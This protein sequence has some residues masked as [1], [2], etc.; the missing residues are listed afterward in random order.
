M[1]RETNPAG[2]T[3]YATYDCFGNQYTCTLPGG[4]IHEKHYDKGNHVTCHVVK[5]EGK[6][7]HTYYKYNHKYQQTKILD[8]L[9]REIVF[10]Y[11]FDGNV[12][13]TTFPKVQNEDGQEIEP[14][15][16][17]EYNCLGKKTS[18]TTPLRCTTTTRYNSRGSPT[19]ITYPD[20]T[21]EA[22][23]YNLDGTLKTAIDQKGYETVYLYNTCQQ[24]IQKTV[25]GMVVQTFTYNSFHVTS[26][27]DN[28]GRFTT[29]TYDKAGRKDSE[30]TE[31][32]TIAYSYDALGFLACTTSQ[33]L[34][35]FTQYNVLGQ[36]KEE[37]EENAEKEILARTRYFYDLAGNCEEIIRYF[38]D[39]VVIE[40]TH[41]DS[42]NRAYEKK[43][44]LGHSTLIFYSDT[45]PFTI[46]EIDPLG[47][48][49]ITTF[50]VLD[51]PISVERKNTFG[52]Q[53]A[54]NEMFYTA[55]G[56][57]ALQKTA[58]I[59]PDGHQETLMTRFKYDSMGRTIKV[60]EAEG[61][62]KQKTTTYGYTLR[63]ERSS[64]IKPDGVVLSYIFDPLGRLEDLSS[65]IDDCHYR[66]CYEK[67][68]TKPS[69]IQD[70]ITGKTT[71]R[72]YDARGRLKKETLATG[73]TFINRYDIQGRRLQLILPD[74]SFIRYVYKTKHLH[75]VSRYDANG[76]HAYTHTYTHYDKSGVPR[77]Q[78]LI[79]N[80]GTLGH[81]IDV[82]GR[83][84]H[85]CST[86]FNQ[87]ID[88]IDPCG[89]IKE[90]RTNN[91]PRSFFYDSLK[92]LIDEEGHAYVC[93]S[94]GRRIEKDKERQDLNLLNHLFSKYEYDRNGNP[95]LK[96]DD[97]TEYIY[98]S[99]DRLT[100]VVKPS[101]SRVIYTYD[102][103]HR[104]LA[105]T[106]YIWQND[107]WVQEE[108]LFFLYDADN[109]IGSITS[110]GNVKELR[111]LGAGHGAEIGAAVA[112]ELDGALYAPVHDLFGNITCLIDVFTGTIASSIEYTAFGEP[113]ASQL[114]PWGFSSK[115]TDAETGFV[116][117]GRRYYVP[118]LGRFLTPDPSG[119]TD[120]LNLYAYLNHSPLTA[121]DLYGLESTFPDPFMLPHLSYNFSNLE[122]N[123]SFE[124]IIQGLTL[125]C[126]L[127]GA[128]FANIAFHF[129]PDLLGGEYLRAFGHF[130]LNEAAPEK[131]PSHTGSVGQINYEKVRFTLVNGILTFA[132]DCKDYA[133][134]VSHFLG[135]AIVNYMYNSS[136][137]AIVDL[138]H[139]IFSKFGYKDGDARTLS[140]KWRVDIDAMGGVNGGGTINH[141]AFSEGGLI[142]KNALELLTPEERQMIV[143][144]TFG[145]ASLFS[146]SLAR[147]VTHFVSVR[148]VVPMTDT[149]N[150]IKAVYCT[151]TSRPTNVV[152]VGTW[153]GI[154][155]IDHGFTN[156]SYF[157]PMKNFGNNVAEYCRS[158]H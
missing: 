74:N 32:E 49:A 125:M 58:L 37:R 155:L 141:V 6:K 10:E 23:I 57:L 17:A 67:T 75:T 14:V 110:E 25:A 55:D 68:T 92:H 127:V 4:V 62:S 122:S 63:G 152:F 151:L 111:V 26:Q 33:D 147:D 107:V 9:N 64:I 21:T 158:M 154:P 137:G 8:Y 29:Y 80:L 91:S 22:F 143:V 123:F 5:A 69:L 145:S 114:S 15:A 46:T 76:V 129:V 85:I 89:N 56:D 96:R 124:P 3:T 132:D 81:G 38:D 66:Y 43:D 24:L 18:E 109:E 90:I 39:T 146:S 60:V 20:G 108:I 71:E 59:S 36:L 131:L 30:T 139:S 42:W 88:V 50:D 86:Y 135:G 97:N 106:F 100:E 47:N 130:L 157:K 120:G 150:Y 40:V 34:H 113:S 121:H 140:A 84:T 1:I 45:S 93:D 116:Y 94:L 72:S 61:A 99:L 82:L 53:T 48:Q 35:L 142:T 16:R 83:L 101:V 52:V 77:S 117:F 128:V 134:L 70:E 44:P 119:F 41:H 103:L 118:E 7:H 144:Y 79:G 112:V 133:S 95:I 153:K 149:F 148:D 156:D 73:L 12:I 27:T 2:Q 28:E 54:F 87:Q 65:S 31:G 105:K 126:N 136:E 102:P 78:E 98:D 11:D 138:C 115:R 104:R 19:K 51:R 13:K